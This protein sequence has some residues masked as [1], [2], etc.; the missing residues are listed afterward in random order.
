MM[1]HARWKECADAKD[2][3]HTMLDH[4]WNCAPFWRTFPV[5]P[6]CGKKLTKQGKSKCRNCLIFVNADPD[7][8][9]R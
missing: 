5:C 3:T 8:R 1:P 9:P 2:V 4:C 7:E 6:K